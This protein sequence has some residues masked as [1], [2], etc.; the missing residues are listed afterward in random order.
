MTCLRWSF[1]SLRRTALTDAYANRSLGFCPHAAS[2]DLLRFSSF[3][4]KTLIAID[5]IIVLTNSNNKKKCIHVYVHVYADRSNTCE[6]VRVPSRRCYT[7]SC[8]RLNYFFNIKDFSL[9]S[10]YYYFNCDYPLLPIDQFV[11]R[12]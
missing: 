2:N 3:G 6:N 12:Q 4:R 8:K 11:V 10:L 7:F 1:K 5:R 9:T